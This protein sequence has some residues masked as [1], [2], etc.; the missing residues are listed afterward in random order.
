MFAI[1]DE[2]AQVIAGALQV[3]VTGRF[4]LEPSSRGCRYAFAEWRPLLRYH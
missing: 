2:T 4:A 3:K 1:Q